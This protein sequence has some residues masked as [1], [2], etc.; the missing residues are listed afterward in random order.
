MASSLSF[1]GVTSGLQTDALIQAIMERDGLP[2]Q[3][4]KDRQTLNTQRSAAL[5][6]MRLSMSS[7]SVSMAAFYDKLNARAVSSTDSNATFVT[8][9]ATG[10]V[11]GSYEVKVANVATKGQLGPV[12]SGGE[13]TSMAV[14]DPNAAILTSTNGSFAVQGTDGVV[15]AFKL[16][17]NSLNGLRDAI[18]ASG[19]GVTATVVN[20]GSGA[21][22]YQLILTAK[23]TGTGTTGGVV[24]L[25]AIK[26]E[27]AGTTDTTVVASLGIAAGTLTGTIAS[28]GDLSGGLSSAGSGI[29]QDA[30]F[31]VNGVQLTRKTNT[32]KDAVDG[33]TFTLRKGDGTN[34]TTLTVAQDKSAATAGMQDVLTKFNALLKVYKDASTAVK[35]SDGEVV[36]GALTGDSTARSVINQVRAALNSN[37]DG[38]SASALYKSGAELGIKTAIDGTLSLDVTAF[39]A[40]LDKDPDAVKRVFSFSGASTNGNVSFTGGS[41][42]T[43]TGAVDFD[44]TYGA[45]GAI[46]G[47]LTYNGV[48]YSGLSGVNGTLQG[49]TGSPLE[50]LNLA[51]TGS[52]TGTL[53]LSRGV[54]QKLQD[55]IA[56]LTSYTG[57]I[58]TTRT[59]LDEQNKSLTQRIE[60]GQVLLDKR[61]A[62]LKA[63][64]DMMEATLSQMRSASSSLSGI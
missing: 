7:L 8:A 33:V 60:S 53:T 19:A 61:K 40:A 30:L 6:S 26:N 13:P 35:G 32:V 12:M 31:S 28:P 52:G 42:A 44:V 5:N 22:P 36:P 45:G 1:Q 48:T 41:S 23:E 18:N 9:T 20:S 38:I 3:R 29:A 63:Q 55:L 62:V 14:A 16:T 56:N 51:V 34:A 4:L 10:A 15:K 24:R 2:V 64:F 47:S 58:E 59:G 50:G 39:Q 11:G 46:S 25:A 43:Q 54:G 17:N 37:P 57:T 49:P 27:D 21:N